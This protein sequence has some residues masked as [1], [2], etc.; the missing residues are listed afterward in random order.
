[1]AWPWPWPSP[2]EPV[3]LGAQRQMYTCMCVVLRRVFVNNCLFFSYDCI[4]TAIV[5]VFPPRK[6]AT[7]H[8]R[9]LLLARQSGSQRKPKSLRR[10]VSECLQLS[11]SER[12]GGLAALALGLQHSLSWMGAWNP[13]LPE[14]RPWFQGNFSPIHVVLCVLQHGP[15]SGQWHCAQRAWGWPPADLPADLSAFLFPERR[16][17]RACRKLCCWL[18]PAR[19]WATAVWETGP[20][21]PPSPCGVRGQGQAFFPSKFLGFDSQK[22]CQTTLT[23]RVRCRALTCTGSSFQPKLKYTS[24]TGEHVAGRRHSSADGERLNFQSRAGFSIRPLRDPFFDVL[25]LPQLLW[26]WFKP[27]FLLQPR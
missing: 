9:R 12:T 2:P 6:L 25:C 27:R 4:Y 1:M 18:V 11:T 21:S 13:M 7:R 3:H 17:Q 26:G 10:N 5:L 22:R 16:E 23:R 24:H 14:E 20:E 8:C 19:T 15:A